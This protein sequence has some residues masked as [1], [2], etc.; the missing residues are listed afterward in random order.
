MIA[1]ERQGLEYL[2]REISATRDEFHSANGYGA[3]MLLDGLLGNGY[4]IQQSER[5]A[6]SERGQ[7]ALGDTATA[8][9]A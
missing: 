6:L 4:A 5:V 9:Q 1:R 2:G 3:A 7:R 8:L